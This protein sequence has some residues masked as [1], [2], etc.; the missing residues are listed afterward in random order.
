VANNVIL[1]P[2]L[3]GLNLNVSLT[4]EALKV[5]VIL[6]QCHPDVCPSATTSASSRSTGAP[7]A[8]K[9]RSLSRRARVAIAAVEKH[10]EL[11]TSRARDDVRL[12]V[13]PL[14]FGC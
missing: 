10:G 3:G 6:A 8:T 9:I 13:A 11:V 14:P 5:A 12:A 2:T 1:A 7:G 4:D